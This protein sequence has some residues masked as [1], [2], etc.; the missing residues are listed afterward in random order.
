MK[1]ATG[2]L[3]VK[4]KKHG[5]W[6][7]GSSRANDI[8]G[9]QTSFSVSSHELWQGPEYMKANGRKSAI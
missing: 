1:L 4:G 6:R 5:G 7:G 9:K 2:S 3:H 8:A